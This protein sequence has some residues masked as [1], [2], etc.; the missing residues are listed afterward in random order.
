MSC[1]QTIALRL[2][3]R[4]TSQYLGYDFDSLVEFQGKLVFFGDDGIFEE[5]GGTLDGADIDA[6][7]D[8]PLHDFGKREQKSIE[9]AG[10]GYETEGS[11]L[12]TITPDE[13]VAHAREI[14][15]TPT[16]DA[17]DTT[18]AKT[19]IIDIADNHGSL[20]SV[21]IRS[22]EFKKDGVLLALTAFDVVC[23]A[24][25]TNPVAYLPVYAFDT[26]KDKTSSGFGQSWQ[27]QTG[28]VADQRLICVFNTTQQFNEIVINN[29]HQ[30][31]ATTTPGAQ[32]IKIYLTPDS[33]T[34]TVYG[35]AIS[36][37]Q[38]VFDGSITKHVASDVIEDQDLTLALTAQLQ[39]DDMVTLRK[40]ANGRGRYWGVR[41]ANIDGCNFSIDYVGLAPVVLKR[42]SY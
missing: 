27:S 21:G 15:F 42:R 23:Y 10:L 35:S 4:A 22:V 32:N 6:H 37:S 28:Q 18:S 41:V 16:K 13:V 24:T 36:N 5:G 29:F 2:P 26:S 19:A 34:S 40:V 33:I 12:M 3:N 20:T 11:L 8:L 39:Q 38:E 1:S 31:G 14:T 7:F 9:A 25:T 30:A 17:D